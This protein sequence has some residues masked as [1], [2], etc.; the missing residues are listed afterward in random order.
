MKVIN[1]M[2]LSKDNK[3]FALIHLFFKDNNEWYDLKIFELGGN[4]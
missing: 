2:E 1:Y 4:I 3:P